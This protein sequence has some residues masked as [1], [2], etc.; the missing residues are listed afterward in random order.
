[1]PDSPDLTDF[2]SLDPT[3]LEVTPDTLRDLLAQTSSAALQLIDCREADEWD[4]CHLDRALLV[5]LSTFAESAPTHI[6][7]D[8][9]VVVYCHHGMRSARAT[10]WLRAKG[11]SA[12]SLAGGIELWAQEID[13]SLP[14]Y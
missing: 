14:R 4:I 8:R 12:W 9:P 13:P 1:M 10:Q 5:P 7:T 11:Y 6:H 3:S 2:R